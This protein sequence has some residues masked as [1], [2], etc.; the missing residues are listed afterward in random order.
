MFSGFSNASTV[1]EMFPNI[2]AEI[3]DI[4]VVEVGENGTTSPITSRPGL[5]VLEPLELLKLQDAIGLQAKRSKKNLRV[6]DT[7]QEVYAV[8]DALNLVR[9]T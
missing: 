8:I 7:Q 1:R 3:R 9:N 5:E 6:A 2:T 4:L